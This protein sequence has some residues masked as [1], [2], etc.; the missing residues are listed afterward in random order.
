MCSAYRKSRRELERRCKVWRW[1][2]AKR[3]GLSSPINGSKSLENICEFGDP[4]NICFG[5]DC[6]LPVT[7]LGAFW[8]QGPQYSNKRLHSNRLMEAL[9]P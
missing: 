4:Y 8:S 2:N 1:L 7:G 3:G 5:N 9:T 6:F